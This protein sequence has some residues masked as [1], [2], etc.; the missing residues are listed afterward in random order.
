[1]INIFYIP[2]KITYEEYSEL[3]LPNYLH[4]LLDDLP[5]YA[6]LFDILVNLNTSF[7]KKGKYIN[8]NIIN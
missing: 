8:F 4:F 6:F 1:M 3:V 7:F 5:A 2:I